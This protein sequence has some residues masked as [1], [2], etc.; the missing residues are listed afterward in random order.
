MKRCVYSIRLSKPKDTIK[1]TLFCV[2]TMINYYEEP[3]TKQCQEITSLT[4]IDK[5]SLTLL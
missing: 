5:P 2:K 4:T 3:N 1:K